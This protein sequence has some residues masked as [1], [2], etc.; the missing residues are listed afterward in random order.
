MER[1]DEARQRD[2]LYDDLGR[3]NRENRKLKT[4]N[5]KLKTEAE[6]CKEQLDI[7][8]HD[9]D[10]I[11]KKKVEYQAEN[12]KLQEEVITGKELW[13][14]AQSAR[15]RL[16][17]ENDKL[18]EQLKHVKTSLLILKNTK[19]KEG[20]DDLPARLVDLYDYMTLKKP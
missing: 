8:W 20:I 4:E 7:V 12:A 10:E 9:R 17:L 16:A 14:E 18:K 1:S 6:L 3:A 2:S 13:V 19:T 15:K 5:A 11:L